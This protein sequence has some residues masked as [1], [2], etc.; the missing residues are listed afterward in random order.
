MRGAA[1]RR[2]GLLVAELIVVRDRTWFFGLVRADG[3]R[4]RFVVGLVLAEVALVL[5]V[6]TA[7]AV[8]VLTAAQPVVSSFATS[9][10]GIDVQLVRGAMVPRM[11]VG[12]LAVLVLA[13]AY[14]AFKATRQ[15]PLD[16]LERPSV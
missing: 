14:P 7:L 1:A 13:V 16:V 5:V 15:D 2:A 4:T 6:G 3:G 11:L 8:G 12:A 9:T 10:F